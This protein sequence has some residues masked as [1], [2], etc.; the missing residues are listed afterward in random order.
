MPF[1]L[2]WI[3]NGDSSGHVQSLILGAV[4]FIAAVQLFALGVIGDLLAGQRVMT[5]R[6]FERV[7]RVE[8]ALGVEPSHYERGAPSRCRSCEWSAR[9]R[10]GAAARRPPTTARPRASS[11]SASASPALITY[12]Y[13][14]IASHALSKPD[15]GQITVLWSAV[16]ITIS[17]LYRPVEQLLSRH[18]SERLAK[19]EPIGQQMRVAATIQ[20]GLALLFA[21]LALALRGPIQDGLLEGNETLYWVFFGAVLF[22]AASYFAR[23]FL[24]GQR[25]LRPLHG[26]D[27]LRVVLP[28]PLRGAGRGRPA[29]RPVRGRGRH[30]R[31]ARRSACWSS[32]SPSPGGRRKAQRRPAAR[33]R[34]GGR[35]G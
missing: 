14:L 31:R 20:L 4:L 23:G 22:Y 12:A 16:F 8:L 26:A 9:Q 29:Q 18:I 15:Y 24:A 7:R 3:F 19:G 2:D 32:R 6:V 28:H 11:R 34:S 21:V 25:T 1:L 30:R 33:T 35:A 5:Q 17:T 27:P 10:G 13:F